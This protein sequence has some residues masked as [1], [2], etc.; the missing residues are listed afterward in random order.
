MFLAEM[1]MSDGYL[2]TPRWLNTLIQH[3]IRIM[4]TIAEKWDIF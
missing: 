1:N 4:I 2:I 3:R